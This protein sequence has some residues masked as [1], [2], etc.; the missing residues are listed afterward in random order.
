MLLALLARHLQG[1]RFF[2]CAHA[3]PERRLLLLSVLFFVRAQ[4]LIARFAQMQRPPAF[5]EIKQRHLRPLF[6]DVNHRFGRLAFL[7]MHT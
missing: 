6:G 2:E 7:A 4:R 1:F 5:R 3:R